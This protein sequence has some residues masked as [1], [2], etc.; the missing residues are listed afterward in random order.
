YK[1]VK[2]KWD[3]Q[4]RSENDYREW[5]LK[6]LNQ[7]SRVIKIS[8]S[9]YLFGFLRN[10]FGLYDDIIKFGFNFRQ[11]IIIDKGLRSVGGRCTSK[12]KMFPTA[13][14]TILFFTQDSRSEL[15][16][17]LK[18]R[19][20]ESGL[21]G[22]EINRKLGCKSGMWS[23]Y[24]RP[25]NSQ[26]PTKENWE[27][28]QQILDFDRAYHDFAPVFNTEMGIT[29]VWNDL[30]FYE[31]DRFHPTQ[32]PVKLIERIIKAS[33]NENMIVLDPFMGSGATAIAC[34]NL[35]RYYVGIEREIEYLNNSLWRIKSH[36]TDSK[37]SASQFTQNFT[38]SVLTTKSNTKLSQNSYYQLSLFG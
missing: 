9:L 31:E 24:T 34:L 7:I 4:W 11:Q 29:D 16:S 19:Q 14:E 8:G 18:Q 30:D 38:T 10:L 1:I 22:L 17:F 23:F 28:L 5:C 21:T 27:K 3:H 12:Y 25:N 35:N 6:W 32:K 15:K 36:T 26:I 33:S 13:T 2:Q 37:Q 20:K